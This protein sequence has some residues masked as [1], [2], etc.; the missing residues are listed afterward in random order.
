MPQATTMSR[1]ARVAETYLRAKQAVIEKGFETEIEWQDRIRLLQITERDFLREAAWVVLSAG[2]RETVIRQRFPAVSA[3]FF[4]WSSASRIVKN[5]GQCRER[6]LAAFAH[7]GK[8]DA[9]ITIA[10]QIFAEGFKVFRSGTEQEGVVF[11]KQ[12]PFM[13]PATAYHLAKNIGLDVVKPDRHLLRVAA[14]AGYDSPQALCED[15]SELVGDRLAVV[16][17]VLWR[18]AT[19]CSDYLEYFMNPDATQ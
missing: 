9:I 2:M 1:Q 12:L 8:I 14:A 5:S 3:A 19:L 10:Q 16:D 18:F 13:G 11:I 7:Q 15:I 4:S 6:G 17:L